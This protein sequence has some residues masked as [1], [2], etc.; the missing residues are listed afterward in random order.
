MGAVLR[1]DDNDS[2]AAHTAHH[3]D[4]ASRLLRRLPWLD[5][6]TAG[7]LAAISAD[8]ANTHPEVHALILFGSVA[9]HE[10]RPITH[11]Q[12]SDVDLLALV[13]AGAEGDSIPLSAM[14]ALHH[15][16]GEREYAHP[17]RAL[18]VQAILAPVDLAGWDNLFIANVAR[19]GVLLWA[20]RALPDALAPLAVRGA[21]FAPD[22]ITA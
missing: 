7:L 14:V 21:V 9:R 4:G 13:D 11:R 16:I 19:D 10:E 5:V 18:G 8:L 6:G 22:E 15:T 12:P 3:D 1:S 20:R 17:V 2:V